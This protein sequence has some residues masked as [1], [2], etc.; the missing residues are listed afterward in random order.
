M[1]LA[2][3]IF[4]SHTVD[5]DD[6]LLCA[7]L[8]LAGA[9]LLE[10]QVRRAVRGG[11]GHIILLVER[12]PA[13]LIAAIDRLRR[14]DIRIDVARSV[15]DAADRIHPEE[16]VLVIDDGCLAGAEM[17]RRLTDAGAPAV[18]SLADQPGMED[19]ERIDAQRRWAGIALIDGAR[20]HATADMLGEWDFALTLLR[21]ALQDGADL[22][23]GDGVDAPIL[24]RAAGDLDRLEQR[25][26]ASSSGVREGWPARYLFP[27]VEAPVF[28]RIARS[29]ADAW[30]IG[31][32]AVVLALMALPFAAVG[33]FWPALVL[34]LL[35]GPVASVAQ[36]L[37]DVRITRLRH[38]R[39]LALARSAIAAGV[40]LFA[41][42][43]M[44]ADGQWGWL[45]VAAI[46]TGAMVALKAE[47]DMARLL[48]SRPAHPMLASTDGLAWQFLPF[49]IPGEWQAGLAV[50][51]L[52]AAASF[53]VTQRRLHGA[54][55]HRLAGQQD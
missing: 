16:A 31:V 55:G 26:I 36:R 2:A 42:W 9:T 10:H 49:A 13:S 25:I 22:I 15:S 40:L 45:L 18:L 24:A 39:P 29:R 3:L 47:L 17:I 8:P 43:K 53:V 11:A 6:Q 44:G 37:A 38:E 4:A 5:D 21:H 46:T 20:L 33:L 19:H 32:A 35:S 52:A 14:D 50:A 41:G 28:G 34:M 27:L 12:L 30:W 23:G 1:A 54:L 51:A 7:A 48:D